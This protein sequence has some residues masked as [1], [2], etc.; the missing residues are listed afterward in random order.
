MQQSDRMAE[1]SQPRDEESMSD[2]A[3][4]RLPSVHV[5]FICHHDIRST[6]DVDDVFEDYFQ[7]LIPSLNYTDIRHNL[8]TNGM[9]DISPSKWYYNSC[10]VTSPQVLFTMDVE[11]WAQVDFGRANATLPYHP[12]N[13]D[14]KNQFVNSLMGNMTSAH[15][16]EYFEEYVCDDMEIFRSYVDHWS[17][18]NSSTEL[19]LDHSLFL[20]CGGVD[21]VYYDSTQQ[22][23]GGFVVFGVLV[24]VIML[25]MIMTELQQF[26]NRGSSQ[27]RRSTSGGS[28]RRRSQQVDYAA[29]PVA[30][31]ELEMV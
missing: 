18:G 22:V 1:S 11:G 21:Y 26:Q 24:G 19:V 27:R 15:V 31:A 4:I 8:R 12:G 23:D 13:L 7:S 6:F 17:S 14:E 10:N 2:E 9:K 28:R 20:L 25:S 29:A 30:T 3:T 5:Q 16:Q